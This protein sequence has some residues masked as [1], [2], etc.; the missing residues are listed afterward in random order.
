MLKRLLGIL[1]VFVSFYSYHTHA[2]DIW[3]FTIEWYD[4]A[5]SLHQD[6]SMDVTEKINVYFSEDRHGIFREI[7]IQ[8]ARGDYTHIENLSA[9][10]DPV[11][12]NTIQNNNYTLKIWSANSTV[13]WP[14]TY[15]ITYT[16]E[17]AIKAFASGSTNTSGAWQELYWN[18]IWNWRKT[19]VKNPT[20]T[21]SLPKANSFTPQTMFLVWWAKGEKNTT[22]TTISQSSGDLTTVYWSIQTTLQPSQ[23]VTLWLQ[24]PA[25]YFIGDVHYNDMFYEAPGLSRWQKIKNLFLNISFDGIINLII[26]WVVIWS[27]A[28]RRPR[29][30]ITGKKP[31]WKSDKAITPYYLPPRNI[32]PSQAFWFWFNAQNSQIFVALL[33]YRATKWWA[34]ISY[35]DGKKYFLWF[36]RPPSYHIVEKTELPKDWSEYDRMLLA[37]FFGSPDGQSDDIELTERS[38]NKMK[39]V[40]SELQSLMDDSTKLYEKKWNIFTRKYILTAEWEQLFEEM[41]WFRE[42]L[43]KVEKPV[44]EKAL[45]EDP[46]YVNKVLPWAVLFGVETSLLQLCEDIIAKAEWYDSYNGRP[47]NV[48]TFNSMTSNIKSSVIAPSS[49]GWSSWS[50]FG[51]GGGFSW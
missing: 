34:H 31:A 29:G 13:I 23:W 12:E 50:W 11:A 25:D 46:W 14:K 20:F 17:N 48:V 42:F 32:E 26:W 49:S 4:V 15:T 35:K 39:S 37:Q 51:W 19:T 47:L 28:L 8:D 9:N 43:S 38:Y 36:K 24:F 44:L 10:W 22:Y 1:L 33:Y 21:I 3:W 7:P 6:G 41:R 2:A 5:M 27:V 18:V 45:Q 40:L 30:K 16:V